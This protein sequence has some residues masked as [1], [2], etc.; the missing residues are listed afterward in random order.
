MGRTEPK[1]WTGP[2]GWTGPT[3]ATLAGCRWNSGW[4]ESGHCWAGLTAGLGLLQLGRAGLVSRWTGP[5]EIW[6]GP[7]D[8]DWS[9][10]SGL[11]RRASANRRGWGGP[12]RATICGVVRARACKEN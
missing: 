9:A 7:L 10:G 11:V 12:P 8:L 6:T 5:A 3:G 2:K 1:S 4:A